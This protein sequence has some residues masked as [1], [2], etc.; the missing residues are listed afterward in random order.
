[1][2]PT[3]Q[4]PS[5]D[6]STLITPHF[7]NCHRC[8]AAVPWEPT[9]FADLGLSFLDDMPIHCDPCELAIAREKQHAARQERVEKCKA[10]LAACIG[11]RIRATDI[12]HPEFNA[13]KWATIGKTDIT[14]HNNIL[15]V[16][17]A[18]TCKSRMLYLLCKTATW[19]GYSIDWIRTTD[20]TIL[21]EQMKDY[22]SRSHARERLQ[23]LKFVDRLVL[24]DLGKT[25]WTPKEEEIA[26]EILD[27][28]YEHNRPVWISANTHPEHLLMESYFT[29]DRGAPLVGRMLESAIVY[30]LSHTTP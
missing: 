17:P 11:E 24:D 19:K 29:R 7:K 16:G 6:H 30:N 1:M 5:T 20:I 10:Q 3:A 2:E 28:R 13:S 15:L 27:Y 9:Q 25:K 22:A 23:R 21:S 8:G 12:T 4:T 26:W 18:G 14:A